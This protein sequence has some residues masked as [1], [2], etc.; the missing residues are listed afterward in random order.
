MASI[1]SGELSFVKGGNSGS[2]STQLIALA[3]GNTLM[4]WVGPTSGGGFE[5]FGKVVDSA[6]DPVGNTFRLSQSNAG[7]GISSIDTAKID[8]GH[9]AIVFN[10]YLGGGGSAPITAAIFDP[11]AMALSANASIPQTHTIDRMASDTFPGTRAYVDVVNGKLA[12]LWESYDYFSTQA[13]GS[14]YDNQ[15]EQVLVPAKIVETS[16]GIG[17]VVSIGNALGVTTGNVVTFLDSTLTGVEGGV[18]TPN[19]YLGE[20]YSYFAPQALGVGVITGFQAHDSYGDSY[21]LRIVG[22]HV[23]G[24][25]APEGGSSKMIVPYVVGD[26]IVAVYGDKAQVLSYD[27]N[28]DLGYTTYVF[29]AE[30]PEFTI[31]SD[32]Y[33][34]DIVA[35]GNGFLAVWREGAGDRDIVGQFFTT[36]GTEVGLLTEGDAGGDI[37]AGTN[38]Q[39]LAGNVLGN[40]VG[41]GK[42]VTDVDGHAVGTNTVILGTYG[43]LTISMDGSYTYKADLP[44]AIALR[45]DEAPT[46]HFTYR[47][48]TSDGDDDTAG[49]SFNVI[50]TFDGGA[51]NV[52]LSNNTV[53]ENQSPGAEVG[54]I[55]SQGEEDFTYELID[56]TGKP[57]EI[58][59]NGVISTTA[60]LD[61]EAHSSYTLTVKL[62]G[63]RSGIETTQTFVV[64]VT[65]VDEAPSLPVFTSSYT[66]DSYDFYHLTTSAT[67]KIGSFSAVDPEG[68]LVTYTI[69]GQAYGGGSYPST[70]KF[71]MV[72]NELRVS[73]SLTADYYYLNIIAK[74]A[75]GNISETKYVS[76]NV[77][78]P[79]QPPVITS[80]GGGSSAAVTVAENTK[81]VTDV[82]ASISAGY[83]IVGGADAAKFTIDYHS[84]ELSFRSA[85]NFEAPTDS[86]RDNS[87]QVI[88]QAKTGDLF[89]NQTIT[90]KVADANEFTPVISSNG[91]GT[92]ATVS[93][94]EN[95]KA[96]TTVKA[97]DA[98]KSAKVTYS[99]AGGADRALFSINATTGA[100][101]FKTA[102]NFEAPKDAGKNNVYDVIVKASDGTKFDQQTLAIKVGNVNEF[103]P[104]I[105]SNG[106]STS[107]A[108][109]VNEGVK[110]VTT[111]KA[112]DADTGTVLKYAISGGADKGLFTINATT[113]ALT[114][115]T[116]P[117]FDV[118]KDAGK[119]NV[120]DVAVSASDGA[121]VDTQ[122]I[123]VKV[124]DVGAL[125]KVMADTGETFTFTKESSKS[126]SHVISG[127][128]S[129]LDRIDL[130]RIDADPAS[131]DQVLRFVSAFTPAKAGEADGQVRVIDHGR[132]VKVEIDWDGNGRTDLTLT[133]L[134][135]AKLHAGDFI[136]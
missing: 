117:N 64:N 42:T 100:L 23:N 131:G 78:P 46:E 120:Y 51:R 85:P 21:E 129:G 29:S 56:N 35:Q 91:G 4:V 25:W 83:Y 132:D 114:F 5:A 130:S 119:N 8:D 66:K 126:G 55:T 125:S 121:R 28:T 109:S 60:E 89:D 62:T 97:A 14:V 104:V 47:A 58:D 19:S 33:P 77:Q 45:D 53:L 17:N 7:E 57:F 3:D 26:K 20:S 15:F 70:N 103:A 88:V 13:F 50:G 73:G 80:N 37:V 105:T 68:G 90:V 82:D 96:V 134:D 59:E 10:T 65:D 30:G 136:L 16:Q 39:P 32:N 12:V 122:N 124:K 11:L 107:A 18:V 108:V 1:E 49:L 81:A 98:D 75:H 40:D 86:N 133:V 38:V 87:Y 43:T 31:D 48:S 123:A 92:S 6:G 9:V 95:A 74:D 71:V 116:A 118:P 93:I 27:F 128:T 101:A 2:S 36:D 61:R 67:G 63:D 112:T 127:F 135:I 115:K 52:G 54:H 72:G 41:N 111:V 113:G 94:L 84:G 106:G 79:P 69:S 76:L 102:P 22:Y 99:I 24:S 44:A 110:T 34:D